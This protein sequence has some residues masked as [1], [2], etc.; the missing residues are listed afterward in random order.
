[1]RT[2]SERQKQIIEASGKI[3]LEKGIKGLTTKQLALEMGFTEGAIY[4]HFSSKEEIIA[5]LL[6]LFQQNL[7]QR[8]LPIVNENSTALDKL[9]KVFE[10]QFSF[11]SQH[12][13][14][15]IA[16]LS[17]GLFEESEKINTEIQQV[18]QSKQGILKQIVDSGKK[19]KEIN[20]SLTTD[21]CIH[22]LAGSFRLMILKWKMAAFSFDLEIEGNKMMLS[23]LE[24]INEPKS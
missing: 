20:Q 6:V 24:L 14:Y 10:S 8:L 13:Y 19:D 7:E 15:V 3:L 16:I 4:R 12:P 21:N 1:M 23:V 18:M 22:I 5:A 9:R 2:L 17:E 11:F